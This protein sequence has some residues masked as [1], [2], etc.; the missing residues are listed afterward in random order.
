MGLSEFATTAGGSITSSA[1]GKQGR[2]HFEAERLGGLEVS[3]NSNLGEHTTTPRAG[4]VAGDRH[5]VRRARD[6]TEAPA[7]AGDAAKRRSPHPDHQRNGLWSRFQRSFYFN[8]RFRLRF[9]AAP[10]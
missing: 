5:A 9:G 2:R 8:R 3:T 6:G 10:P 4:S 1:R 7:G